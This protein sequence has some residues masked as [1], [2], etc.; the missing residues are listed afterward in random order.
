MLI[1]LWALSSGRP[2]VA[3]SGNR[4]AGAEL[5]RRGGRPAGR[6]AGWLAGWL[7]SQC[8]VSAGQASGRATNQMVHFNNGSSAGRALAALAEWLEG[9]SERVAGR[10]AGWARI[11]YTARE[12][13]AGAQWQSGFAAP[14]LLPPANGASRAQNQLSGLEPDRPPSEQICHLSSSSPCLRSVARWPSS[15]QASQP[16]SQPASK[17]LSQS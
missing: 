13:A 17:W 16:A 3:A 5:R 11:I 15:K 14:L 6:L 4:A 7:A 1:R 10:P 8:F 9:A 2:N 12:W